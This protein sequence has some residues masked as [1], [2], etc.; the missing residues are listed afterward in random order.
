M[1]TGRSGILTHVLL[2]EDAEV[3]AFSFPIAS[4]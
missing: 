2:S 3:D 4:T 1:A